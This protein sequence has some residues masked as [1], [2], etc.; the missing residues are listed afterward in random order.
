MSGSEFLRVLAACAAVLAI[1]ACAPPQSAADGVAE[2][3]LSVTDRACVPNEITVKAGKNRFIISNRSMRPLEWEILDGVMVVDERENIVPGLQQRLTTTLKPGQYVM[4]CGLLTNPRGRLIVTADAN[5]PK[6]GPTP[7]EFVSAQAEYKV[8]V[9]ERTAT[10]TREVDQL[11]SALRAGD[12]AQARRLYPLSRQAWQQLAPVAVLLS[13]DYDRLEGGASL[14]RG[15]HN[16]PDFV[17]WHRIESLLFAEQPQLGQLQALAERLQADTATFV[18]NIGSA[19]LGVD[20]LL[21]GSAL[22]A[23][24]IAERKLE[25]LGNHSA[26]T[27]VDD[28]ANNLIGLRKVVTVMDRALAEHAAPQRQALLAGLE[29]LQS[30]LAA[31]PAEGTL[32]DTQPALAATAQQLA[33]DFTMTLEQLGL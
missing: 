17:G 29:R 18:H 25:R 2:T 22:I 21:K 7:L 1:A 9:H 32:D 13:A 12:V 27:D 16:D 33:Q 5:A 28:M 8:F 20:G 4:T 10:M 23:A 31:L 24:R 6:S 15:G 30:A 14:Y 3:Q 11:A 26:G 19:K